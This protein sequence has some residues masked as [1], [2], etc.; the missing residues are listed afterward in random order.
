MSESTAADFEFNY[1]DIGNVTLEQGVAARER[2]IFANAPSR[3]RKPVR[4]GDVIVSTVRTYLKAVA[5]IGSEDHGSVVSTGFA[6]LRANSHADSRFLY[7]IFQSNPFVEAVLASSTGVSYPAINPSALG[8]IKIPVPDIDTQK[9]IAAFLDRETAHIDQ[10]IERKERQIALLIERKTSSIHQQVRR[11]I[12]G[13]NR[14]KDT[15]NPWQ[16]SPAS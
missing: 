2:M 12:G 1:I 7:R 6:V 5:A 11:G 3:A 8:S 9:T 4:E 14:L 15:G 10:L 16:W 13:N